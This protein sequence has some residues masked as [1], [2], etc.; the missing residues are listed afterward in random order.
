V[1][2]AHGPYRAWAS[3][4]E[5]FGRGEDLP[6][7]H[8]VPLDEHLGVA[9][10]ERLLDRLAAAFRARADI[11]ADMLRRHLAAGAIREPRELGATLVA[12]RAR[13]QPLRALAADLR[14][15]EEVRTALTDALRE[16]VAEA[17][18]SLESSARREPRGA[19][20]LIAVIRENHLSAA[21]S[22]PIHPAGPAAQGRPQP[23]PPVGRRVIL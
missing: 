20:E 22:V 8:L 14:L 11:W 2:T 18:R 3:W 6:N 16:M 15:P 4:L 23:P 9:M 17:Q 19:E 12:A 1:L 7:R 5:A 10:R 13:L 21:L